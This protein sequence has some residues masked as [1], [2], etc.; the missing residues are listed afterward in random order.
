[1]VIRALPPAAT[2]DFATLRGEVAR[3]LAKLT[4]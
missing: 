1:V 2:T 3:V 4:A